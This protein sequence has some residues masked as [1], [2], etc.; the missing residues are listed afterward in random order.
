MK[1]LLRIFPIFAI[2]FTIICCSLNVAAY[3]YEPPMPFTGFGVWDGKV[4][5]FEYMDVW[6]KIF[7]V[8][9]LPLIRGSI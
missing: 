5:T 7:S 2:V 8:K 6:K 4:H 9:I 1:Y 3:D